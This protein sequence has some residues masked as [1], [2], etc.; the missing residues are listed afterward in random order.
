[1]EPSGGLAEMPGFLDLL[2]LHILS[3]LI[4]YAWPLSVIDRPGELTSHVAAKSSHMQ[5]GQ[6]E[7]VK[8]S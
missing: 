7:F 3:G 6:I 8:S 4:F 1:M 5:A 2:F